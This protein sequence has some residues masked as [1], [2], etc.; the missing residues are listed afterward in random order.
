M[1]I[2]PLLSWEYY[3]WNIPEH[4]TAVNNKRCFSPCFSKGAATTLGILLPHENKTQLHEKM[5]V[6]YNK[7]IKLKI[8]DC[9]N[10]VL[11]AAEFFARWHFLKNN[12]SFI[13]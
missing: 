10:W 2:A 3:A 11:L 7:K 1:E 8:H 9:S 5:F 6:S 13:L 12:A 4:S